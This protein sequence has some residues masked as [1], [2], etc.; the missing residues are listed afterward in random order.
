MCGCRAKS[1]GGSA[2]A[3][4]GYAVSPTAPSAKTYS[5]TTVSNVST[6]LT[7]VIGV[8]PLYRSFIP[9]KYRTGGGAAIKLYQGEH[10]TLDGRLATYLLTVSNGQVAAV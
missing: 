5:S 10:V 3:Q 8:Q 1:G 6:T 9:A 4:K 7:L 2:V